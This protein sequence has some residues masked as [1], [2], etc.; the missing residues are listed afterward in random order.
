[1]FCSYLYLFFLCIA[2]SRGLLNLSYVTMLEVTARIPGR[3]VFLAGE[4]IECNVTVANVC[5]RSQEKTNGNV[6]TGTGYVFFHL[7]L[8]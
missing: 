8:I 5:R 4:T 3:S 2:T 1:M 6:G 7:I